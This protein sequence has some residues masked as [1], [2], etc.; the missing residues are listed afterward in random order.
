[1][2]VDGIMD[3]SNAINH[4]ADVDAFDT[5]I[6]IANDVIIGNRT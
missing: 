6:N 3:Q 5:T 2:M 4:P 1:M